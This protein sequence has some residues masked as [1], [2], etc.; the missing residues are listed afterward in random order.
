MKTGDL[1][2]KKG[3]LDKNKI[4]M[5]LNI[6]LPNSMGNS[7]VTVLSEGV[8]KKWYINLVEV[9]SESK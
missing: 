2:L 6:T 8:I 3:D 5:V 4:G 1:V 9:V 7:F